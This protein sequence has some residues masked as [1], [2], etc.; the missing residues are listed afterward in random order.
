MLKTRD[1]CRWQTQGWKAAKVKNKRT[2]WSETLWAHYFAHSLFKSKQEARCCAKNRAVS[3]MQQQQGTYG[4]INCDNSKAI[5]KIKKI[6]DEEE[7]N[8]S[9]NHF[10]HVS[11][12]ELESAIHISSL[13]SDV[14][15]QLG[16]SGGRWQVE[17]ELLRDRLCIG[18]ILNNA[19]HPGLLRCI[20]NLK[21]QHFW[22]V[23][24][25]VVGQNVVV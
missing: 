25:W 7:I 18:G 21:I 16:Q 20:V 17:G 9:A 12:D 3:S 1:R 14:L 15:V 5:K 4:H 11:P 23:N 22:K 8:L 10:R 24:V 6:K 2:I 19:Q 13:V